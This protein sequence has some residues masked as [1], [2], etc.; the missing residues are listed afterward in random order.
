MQARPTALCLALAGLLLAAVPASA[1]STTPAAKAVKKP[2]GPKKLG[3]FDDWTAVID[4]EPAQTVCFAFTRPQTSAPAVSGR[5]DVVLTVTERPGDAAARLVVAI[6]A[7]F[8]YAANAGVTVNADPA[9]PLD[10]FTNQRSAFAKDARAAVQAFM[11]GK[12]AVAHSPGPK[13]AVV[14]SFS[15]KGFS[16]AYAA[17]GKACAAGK[18]AP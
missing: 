6:S 1:D 2:A 17:I 5:G 7:G 12:L 9:A 8:A 14:D 16:A 3:V 10:F 13:T 18:A 4:K 15:L 11:K